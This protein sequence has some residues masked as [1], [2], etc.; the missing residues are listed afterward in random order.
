M[1]LRQFFKNLTDNIS[2]KRNEPAFATSDGTVEKEEQQFSKFQPAKIFEREKS[3]SMRSD[4]QEQM[5]VTTPKD[6]RKKDKIAL[7][8]LVAV[9]QMLNDRDLLTQSLE[10]LK[11]R[12]K[13]SDD[14]ITGLV[15]EKNQLEQAI[16]LKD[17]EIARLE[18]QIASRNMNYDQLM[19]DY[20]D[21]QTRLNYEIDELKNQVDIEQER[22]N[23]LNESYEFLQ[24]EN[25]GKVQKL[26]DKIRELE[27]KNDNLQKNYYKMREENSYLLGMFKDFNNRMN[28]SFKAY[29]LEEDVQAKANDSQQEETAPNDAQLEKEMLNKMQEQQPKA[30]EEARLEDAKQNDSGESAKE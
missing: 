9:D 15:Q 27:I 28:S 5:P 10:D 14:H 16:A 3:S 11:E 23:K 29:D 17:T 20:Q 25:V 21:M 18:E 2:V 22:Y 13:H 19:E 24:I 4:S 30:T 7:D 6:N 1:D 12:M 26:E 8:L